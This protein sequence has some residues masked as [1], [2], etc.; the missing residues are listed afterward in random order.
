MTAISLHQ[1][2]LSNRIAFYLVNTGSVIVW[3]VVTTYLLVTHFG[4]IGAV[5]GR[6]ATE[7]FAFQR[8]VLRFFAFRMP[9]R[10]LPIVRIAGATAAMGLVAWLLMI[11]TA[12]GRLS[13][14][15]IVPASV[16]AYAAAAWWLDIV[17]LRAVFSRFT[18]SRLRSRPSGWFPVIVPG[19]ALSGENN[20]QGMKGA[21]ALANRKNSA[22][23]AAPGL[24]EAST[25]SDQPGFET[26]ERQEYTPKPDPNRI[27]GRSTE[28]RGSRK[29]ACAKTIQCTAPPHRPEIGRPFQRQR[30]GR[31]ANPPN[32][33]KPGFQTGFD[34]GRDA[35]ANVGRN[36]R[37]ADIPKKNA[38]CTAPVANFALCSARWL[39]SWIVPTWSQTIRFPMSW[40]P[41]D[42]NG[43]Q[44]VAVLRPDGMQR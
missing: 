22:R 9:F 36:G 13:L 14:V 31:A 27:N 30:R 18:A 16:A 21:V 29:P 2:L 38:S 33:R 23:E 5:W 12:S 26:R 32:R 24:N 41:G 10:L 20:P 28:P 40:Y 43:Q 34:A 37:R 1:F 39:P 17:D 15:M 4:V 3:N 11:A 25:R 19:Q 42:G 44:P 6:L 35:Q 7:I 8:L